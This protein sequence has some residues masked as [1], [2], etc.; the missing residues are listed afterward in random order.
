MYIFS[1]ILS[2]LAL[3]I[4][5]YPFWN[6]LTAMASFIISLVMFNKY[7]ISAKRDDKKKGRT[8]VFSAFIMSCLAL[9]G[10]ISMVETVVS[11]N[12]K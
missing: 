12:L 6:V 10:A 8:L 9:L 1:F 4:C 5:W 3:G 2:M 11:M 7:F